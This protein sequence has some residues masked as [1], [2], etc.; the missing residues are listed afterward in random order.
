ML[1]QSTRA[2]PID[3]FMDRIERNYRDCSAVAVVLN[4]QREMNSLW[5]AITAEINKGI[6]WARVSVSLYDY[7]GDGS[8]F[9]VIATRLAQVALQRNTVIPRIGSGMGWAYDQG[10]FHIRPDLQRVQVFLED[11]W[12]V[13]EGLGRMSNRSFWR[14]T[15]ASAFLISPVSSRRFPTRGISIF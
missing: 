3:A 6:P 15:S 14:E 5:E 2:E 8:R 4:S 13:Q 12:Q 11:Q 7:E 10:T 1:I 9:Y